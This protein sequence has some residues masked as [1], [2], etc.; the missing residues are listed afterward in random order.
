MFSRAV[1]FAIPG[2]YLTPVQLQKTSGKDGYQIVIITRPANM[3]DF[4]ASFADGICIS[5]LVKGC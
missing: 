3:I 5:S 4:G 1:T 2:C